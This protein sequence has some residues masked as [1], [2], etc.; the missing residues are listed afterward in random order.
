MWR[1][2][3]IWWVRLVLLLQACSRL[4]TIPPQSVVERGLALN[5]AQTQQT[6]IAHLAPKVPQLPNFTLR[7]VDVTRREEQTA[8]IFHV[9]GTYQAVM[10]LIGR[11][12]TE[13]GSFD[14][15]LAKE[16]TEDTVSWYLV[17]N[18]GEKTRLV[19]EPKHGSA[20]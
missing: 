10:Q 19:T 4:S 11:K 12:E 2:R 1:I 14:L 13:S 7:Q 9:Q 3:W 16:Q 15:Y 8:G 20:G 18:D 5:I 6:L 17:S